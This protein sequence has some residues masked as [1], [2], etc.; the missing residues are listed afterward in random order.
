MRLLLLGAL[1]LSASLSAQNRPAAPARPAQLGLCVAC[2]GVDGVGRTPGTPHLGGQD[3]AYLRKALLDY[4]DKRR[5]VAPM[6]AIANAL[7]ARDI[8]ALAAWY[9]AQPGFRPRQ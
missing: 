3:E 5:N 2:H 4:R 6:T 7:Q 8:D 9:A 1:L